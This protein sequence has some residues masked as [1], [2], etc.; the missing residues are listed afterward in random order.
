MM[1]M[2]M[3][4]MTMTMIDVDYHDNDAYEKTATHLFSVVSSVHDLKLS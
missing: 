4:T 1:M 3:M 2:M